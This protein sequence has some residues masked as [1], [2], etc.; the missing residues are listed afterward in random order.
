MRANLKLPGEPG[1]IGKKKSKASGKSSTKLVGTKYTSLEMKEIKLLLGSKPSYPI[2]LDF[3]SSQFQLENNDFLLSC[4]NVIKEINLSNNSLTD[5]ANAFEHLDKLKCLVIDNNALSDMQFKGLTSLLTLSLANNRLNYLNSMTDLQKVINLNLSGNKLTAGFDQ[6]SKLKSL[7]VLDLGNNNIDFNISHFYN[8]ILV[9]LKKLPKLAYLSFQGNPCEFNIPEF[10]LFVIYELPQITYLDWTPVT[11]EEKSRAAKLAAADTWK[12]K[13]LLDRD[14]SN[15]RQSVNSKGS[16]V[17]ERTSSSRTGS[18]IHAKR[19]KAPEQE[20]EQEQE[21]KAR[22]LEQLL[23]GLDGETDPLDA[24]IPEG[25]D[26]NLSLDMKDD[27]GAD[28]LDDILN[29]LSPRTAGDGSLIIEDGTQSVRSRMNTVLSDFELASS[30]ASNSVSVPPPQED[31]FY[32]LVDGVLDT[33]RQEKAEE[34][35]PQTPEGN[36]AAN[37]LEILY[38]MINENAEEANKQEESPSKLA[39]TPKQLPPRARPPSR[40]VDSTGGGTGSRRGSSMA[41][42]DDDNLFEL[43]DE[44]MQEKPA[45]TTNALATA[46]IAPPKSDSDAD[47]DELERTINALELT[48]DAT[49]A[50]EAE[51]KQK[52]EE[53]EKRKQAAAEEAARKQQQEREDQRKKEQELAAAAAARKR[54]E[55]QRRLSVQ[56]HQQRLSLQPQPQQQRGDGATSAR[57]S[58]RGLEEVIHEED[59]YKQLDQAVT[60]ASGGS[61]FQPWIA[62]HYELSFGRKLGMG[63]FGNSFEG[64]VRERRV[65]IKRLNLQRFAQPFLDKLTEEC[66]YLST[67]RHP[68]VCDLIAVCVNEEICTVSEHVNGTNLYGALRQQA[69]QVDL[70]WILKVA[71]GIADGMAYLHEKNVLHLDLKSKNVMIDRSQNARINDFGLLCVKTEVNR[72]GFATPQYCAPELL[73]EEPVN[74]RADVYS[75]GL[76]L[77]EMFTREDP[78]KGLATKQIR[79]A[80]IANQRPALPL[81]PFVFTKLIQACWNEMPEKR[82]SF[83]VIVKILS[84]PKSEL[85]KYDPPGVSPSPQPSTPAASPPVTATAAREPGVMHSS[86]PLHHQAQSSSR[87]TYASEVV[88]TIRLPPAGSNKADKLQ[89]VLTRIE[90]MLRSPN[91]QARLKALRAICDFAKEEANCVAIS[92]SPVMALLLQNSESTEEIVKEQSLR[93]LGVLSESEQCAAKIGA[94]AIPVVVRQLSG[95]PQATNDAITLQALKALS[96]LAVP[97]SN[98]SFVEGNG[99]IY[100]LVQMLSRP[101]ELIQMQAATALS[102]LVTSE[103]NQIQFYKSNGIQPLLKLLNSPNPGIQLRVLA[104]LASL[105]TNAKMEAIV[106]KVGVLDRFV[107]LLASKSPLLQ[108]QAVQSVNQFAEK[109]QARRH[110]FRNGVMDALL[111][112]FSQDT[113]DHELLYLTSKALANFMIDEQHCESLQAKGGMAPMLRALGTPFD[114]VR[115]QVTKLV[116][117]LLQN[118]ANRQELV[119]KGGIP[120]LAE[121]LTAEGSNEAIQL[122]ALNALLRIAQDKGQSLE[123]LGASSLIPA[124][125]DHFLENT[126]APM[127]A[128]SSSSDEIQRTAVKLMALL[129]TCAMNKERIALADAICHLVPLTESENEEIRKAAL[130][131]LA[132]ISDNAQCREGITDEE[133]LYPLLKALSDSDAELQERAIWAISNFAGDSDTHKEIRQ[134]GLRQIVELLS[135]SHAM[136]QSLALKAVI[137]LVQKAVNSDNKEAIKQLGGIGKL[138]SLHNSPNRTVSVASR[139]AVELLSM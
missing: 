90:E 133:G 53:E 126:N 66:A 35:T 51:L 99:G 57:S 128:S 31:A 39:A 130:L 73:A 62:H 95:H 28:P 6:L 7:K 68:N 71:R 122:H 125:S 85:L 33:G 38:D 121:M 105:T 138:Q 37:Y 48:L 34:A 45:D 49:G 15:R 14:R 115:E 77:W 13:D 32:T 18:A 110:M 26:L 127:D 94:E 103:A 109:P 50:R 80:V 1:S 59:L 131:A 54:A 46:P 74:G 137:L 123:V 116:S 88:G 63:T 17:L 44:I 65:T 19:S 75:F 96:K 136:C 79:E 2:Y 5:C 78:F 106:C 139:K 113:I 134:I 82:P 102:G 104:T 4:P 61:L 10:R 117:H 86:T 84:Q 23:F 27:D 41:G 119:M 25:D 114:N 93:A 42:F 16:A 36:S 22:L 29:Y 129:S 52:Q 120:P 83:K 67:L 69:S 20:Q 91:M 98:Q 40:F 87:Q 81:C 72:T 97:E 55:E 111:R 132:N 70:D 9:C 124:L 8:R 108:K 43:L 24:T 3:S 56:Q 100:I 92:D 58:I 101:N 21:D 30:D 112:V 135:S 60:S 11:K 47:L 12:D 89:I 76:I 118:E 107:H 64:I